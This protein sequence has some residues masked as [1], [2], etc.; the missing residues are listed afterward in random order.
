MSILRI[1]KLEFLRAPSG[2]G[3]ILPGENLSVRVC[4]VGTFILNDDGDI[5]VLSGK[6]DK[7]L[8]LLNKEL[9]EQCTPE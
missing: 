8:A 1:K 6:A 5:F 4:G 2:K 9:E 3:A 7:V